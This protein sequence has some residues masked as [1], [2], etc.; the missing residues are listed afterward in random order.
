MEYTDIVS[1][2]CLQGEFGNEKR[3]VFQ[4]CLM[5]YT[6]IVIAILISIDYSASEIRFNFKNL[7]D[8]IFAIFLVVIR[9]HSIMVCL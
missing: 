7:R 6:D 2:I 1:L 8:N 5:E 3:E 4:G 9:L